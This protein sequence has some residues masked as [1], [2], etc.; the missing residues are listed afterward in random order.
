MSRNQAF[1]PSGLERAVI[2]IRELN[3]S[4]HAHK[5]LELMQ[6]QEEA[7][8]A[9]FTSKQAQLEIQKVKLDGEERRK[10]LEI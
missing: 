2:A 6:K 10:N 5:T 3:Q 1:D 7:K 8:K 9:E 4:P